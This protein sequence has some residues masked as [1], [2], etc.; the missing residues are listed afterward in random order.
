[1]LHVKI[2]L[3]TYLVYFTG[4]NFKYKFTDVQFSKEIEKFVS[5]SKE[6]TDTYECSNHTHQLSLQ[7]FFFL[8]FLIYY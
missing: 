6:Y 1:M 2:S 5:L 7:V 8:L 3:E 4:T